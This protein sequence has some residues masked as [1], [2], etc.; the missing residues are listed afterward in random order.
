MHGVEIPHG[1]IFRSGQRRRTQ[2]DFTDATRT[3]VTTGV[4]AFRAGLR[5]GQE[6]FTRQRQAGC[7]GCIYR[8][9]CWPEEW[10]HV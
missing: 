8:A 3:W 7:G 10:P 4:E 9:H 2:V 1:F 6:G 5:L